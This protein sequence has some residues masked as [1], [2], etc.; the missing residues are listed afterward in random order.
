MQQQSENP[1][2]PI[3]PA[4]SNAVVLTA[5]TLHQV[6]V[7]DSVS[8]R[9]LR[10]GY[11]DGYQVS[12]SFRRLNSDADS[13]NIYTSTDALAD[14]LVR[15]LRN[16]VR[17]EAV[18]PAKDARL[19]YEPVMTQQ[20]D[21]I[22]I[23]LL[24]GVVLFGFIRQTTPKFFGELLQALLSDIR[25]NKIVQAVKQQ[26]SKSSRLLFLTYQ[27]ITPLL[28]YEFFVSQGVAVAGQQGVILYLMILVA[29]ILLFSLRYS[30]YLLLGFVFDTG[31][32]S[33]HFMQASIIFT[34]ITGVLLI[35]VALVVP[36]VNP[37]WQLILL[38]FGASVFLV[39][40]GW[41]LFRGVKII[42]DGFLSI[43][44]MFLYLCALEI[45][46]V[47]WLYK[48]FAG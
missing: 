42:L 41:M 1:I 9:W 12:N 40:Y 13:I 38:K 4:T 23:V 30:T 18:P 7:A 6:V 44:Y 37:A 34:N 48:L 31:Q 29:L 45:I 5:D 35:P 14:S 27:L 3:V 15:S 25:W 33:R 32:Q 47:I 16:K 21:W 2:V 46:P 19:R 24:I 11:E 28:I 36:F 10:G 39:L 43:F 8:I 26:Y 20:K 17:T 22:L